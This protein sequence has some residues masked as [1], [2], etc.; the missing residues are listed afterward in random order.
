MMDAIAKFWWGDNENSNKMHL[1]AWWKLC[2]P[3]NEWGMGF[4]DFHSFNLAMLAKQIW[5]LIDKPNSLCARVLQAKYYP[6]GNILQAGPKAGSSFTWQSLLA[7]LATSKRGFIWRVG[8]GEDIKIWSD[9]WIPS[10]PNMRVTSQQGNT[11]LTKV[12]QLIDPITGQWDVELINSI[13]NVVDANRI[14]RIPLNTKGFNDFIS[15]SLTKHEYF[16]VRSAY[17]IQWR[18]QFGHNDARLA[19]PGASTLNLV[20]RNLWKLDIPGKV[21]KKLE[22]SPWNSSF[23]KNTSK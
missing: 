16:T 6:Q 15:W 7:G 8:N 20:W 1:F 9:P 19:L 17:H 13:F 3:K 14:C 11:I 12:C 10:S 23:K 18:H 4:R 22:S 5:I 2:Y 21:K